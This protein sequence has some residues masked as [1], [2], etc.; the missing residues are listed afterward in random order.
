MTCAMKNRKKNVL[1]FPEPADAAACA[2]RL[3]MQ[4]EFRVTLSAITAHR[5]RTCSPTEPKLYQNPIYWGRLSCLSSEEQ[6]PQVIGK[7]EKG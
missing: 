3:I 5:E 4:V 1:R 7:T 2:P 6:I